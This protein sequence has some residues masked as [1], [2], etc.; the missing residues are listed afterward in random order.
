MLTKDYNIDR[1]D[2]EDLEADTHYHIPNTHE[3]VL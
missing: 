1:E 2:P 3:V